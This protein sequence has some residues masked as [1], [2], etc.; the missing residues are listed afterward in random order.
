MLNK[1]TGSAKTT[2][3]HIHI[4]KKYLW[5]PAGLVTM[6]TLH[7]YILSTYFYI[8]LSVINYNTLLVRDS[9]KT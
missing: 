9:V 4:I 1:T 5:L 8:L 3:S 6:K 7:G 2:W